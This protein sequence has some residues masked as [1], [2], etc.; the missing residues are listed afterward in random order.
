MVFAC[1]IKE[2]GR[3]KDGSRDL[4]EGE[5]YHLYSAMLDGGVRELEMG[6]IL[7]ALRMKGESSSEILGFQRAVEERTNRL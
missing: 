1:Y 6:A 7:I 5:A 2:I 4:S 3:G